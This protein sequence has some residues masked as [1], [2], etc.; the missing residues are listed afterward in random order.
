MDPKCQLNG[1]RASVL[2]KILPDG[3]NE[4]N[5]RPNHRKVVA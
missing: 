5:Q 1:E 4:N 2:S 3:G